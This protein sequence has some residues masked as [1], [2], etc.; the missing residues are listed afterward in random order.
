MKE[1]IAKNDAASK[2][3]VTTAPAAPVSNG[4]ELLAERDRLRADLAT[5]TDL[6]QRWRAME[7]CAT[8]LDSDTAKFL[9]EKP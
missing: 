9:G 8:A 7:A 5:A 6:L 2:A 3:L 1:C 4:A